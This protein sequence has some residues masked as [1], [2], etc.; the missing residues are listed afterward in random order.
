MTRLWQLSAI[1]ALVILCAGCIES[2]TTVSLARD[3]SG[4]VTETLYEVQ[5]VTRMMSMLR[6]I[7]SA[8]SHESLQR[9]D[10]DPFMDRSRYEAR[11]KR[12][13]E[14][15]T[16]VSVDRAKKRDGSRG[17]RAVYAF[18]HIN[19]L[20]LGLEPNYP[21]PVP[22]SPDEAA[23]EGA[24]VTFSY[25]ETPSTL[26]IAIPWAERAR[27]QAAIYENAL[28]RGELTLEESSLVGHILT[29]FRARMLIETVPPFS[30]STASKVDGDALKPEKRSVVLFDVALGET[31]RS[32][33]SLDVLAGIGAPRNLEDALSK[34][35]DL[36][37]VT[38]EKKDSVTVIF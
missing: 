21:P 22:A 14:G 23:A 36:L 25:K 10:E 29:G 4:T 16:L 1:T 24:R 18:D 31:V 6:G 38:V 27:R 19:A 28:P 11:A 26:K 17:V 33:R 37:G 32:D 2:T 12:M 35:V 34:Y 3:G 7:G 30:N 15:V 9:A 8:L 20:S 5:S 13:G